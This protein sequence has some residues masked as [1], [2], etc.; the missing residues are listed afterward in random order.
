MPAMHT[1]R[2]FLVGALTP[3]VL[4]LPA[5]AGVKCLTD[6]KRGGELCKSFINVKDAYQE[7]YHARHEPEAIW[8]ACV[9]VVF[10]T[11]GHVIQ[12]PRIAEEA[13]GDV[14]KVNL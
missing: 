12:Q 5:R 2:K 7:T 4:A 11:Y 9:A 8:I 14:A 6:N 3:M 13:Y 10:A 1:R